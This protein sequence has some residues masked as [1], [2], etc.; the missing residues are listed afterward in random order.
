MIANLLLLLFFMLGPLALGAVL[1]VLGKPRSRWRVISRFSLLTLMLAMIPLGITFAFFRPAMEMD[2]FGRNVWLVYLSRVAPLFLPA[3][4]LMYY[5]FDEWRNA[6]RKA[7]EPRPVATFE[8]LE[9]ASD[10]SPEEAANAHRKKASLMEYLRTPHQPPQMPV[11][12]DYFGLR[13]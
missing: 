12:R 13:K 7:A 6:G 9:G 1:W 11:K 4:W 2:E 3:M 8:F 10:N 5:L